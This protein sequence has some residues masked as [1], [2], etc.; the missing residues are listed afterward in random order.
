MCRPAETLIIL[1][2]TEITEEYE[3]DQKERVAVKTQVIL[4][5]LKVAV[6]LQIYSTADY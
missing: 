5:F 1:K 6:C 2:Y 4:T 3:Q